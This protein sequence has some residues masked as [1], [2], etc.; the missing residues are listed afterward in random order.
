MENAMLR[1]LYIR[2]F[3]FCLVLLSVRA[4]GAELHSVIYS[5]CNGDCGRV[6]AGPWVGLGAYRYIHL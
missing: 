4:I 2:F 1:R 6:L 3:R 5:L